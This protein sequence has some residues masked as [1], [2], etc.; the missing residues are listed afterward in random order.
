VACGLHRRRQ[1]ILLQSEMSLLVVY[2]LQKSGMII[3]LEKKGK[4]MDGT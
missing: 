4:G 1:A 2:L 3:Q